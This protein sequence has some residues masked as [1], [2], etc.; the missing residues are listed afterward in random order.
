[1]SILLIYLIKASI[2]LASL[3]LVF[4]LFLRKDTFHQLKRF[5]LLA[6]LTLSL[7]LPL[8]DIAPLQLNLEKTNY[9]PLTQDT[10]PV[11]RFAFA[12]SQPATP[13]THNFAYWM[14]TAYLLYL[15]VVL[16]LLA[17]FGIQLFSVYKLIRNANVISQYPFVLASSTKTDSPFSFFRYLILNPEPYESDALWQIIQHE[18][19]HIAG[20][21]TLDRLLSEVYTIFFWFNPFAWLHRNLVKLNLE[22]IADQSVLKTGFSVENYQSN[23]LRLTLPE[24]NF[25]ITNNFNQSGLL[26]RIRMMNKSASPLT[27]RLKFALVLPVLTGCILLFHGTQAKKIENQILSLSRKIIL[28]EQPV[29]PST[30]IQVRAVTGIIKDADRDTPLSGVHIQVKGQATSTQ[31]D[32][33]GKF[34]IN[35]NEKDKILVFQLENFN[36]TEMAITPQAGMIV[37]LKLTDTP[38]AKSARATL[39]GEVQINAHNLTAF[40]DGNTGITG[41]K[42][43]IKSDSTDSPDHKILYLVDGKVVDKAQ[44][45]KIKGEEIASINVY[46]DINSLRK[47]GAEDKKGVIEFKLKK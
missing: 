40:P 38:I 15:A 45:N 18:Q 43:V 8:L 9:T 23:L 32:A 46:K 4:W 22:Y 1:M 47:F 12:D 21:H 42:I 44:L 3:Y 16:F 29:T 11:S 6:N 25:M 41:R 24:R 31:S 36:T 33:S 30:S 17:R 35:V 37:L 13:A 5:V 27:F 34:S 39:S 14:E 7:G 20:Y 2:T 28:P 26:K 10:A 19:V